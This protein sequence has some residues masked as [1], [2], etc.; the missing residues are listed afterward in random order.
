MRILWPMVAMVA[1]TGVAARQASPEL[2][3]T[4]DGVRATSVMGVAGRL[5]VDP[6]AP[7]MPV[8]NP[9]MAARAG[10]RSGPFAVQYG[11]GPVSIAGRTAVARIDLGRGAIKRRVTWTA[12]AFVDDA[13]AA[14]G[15][16]GLPDPV[17]RFQ[18]SAPRAGERVVTL[19]MASGGL[20]GGWGM[21]TALVPING[22]PVRIRFDPRRPTVATAG[23]GV[24]I[25]QAQGGT[26]EGA[27]ASTE[28]A[29]GV[30]RPVRGLR[31][32][33]PLAIGPL[34]LDR[35]LVR[36]SDFGSAASIAEAGAAPPDPDEVV[37]T[38]KGK[39]DRSRD[40]V[41][42]GREQLDRCSS[43]TF[44]KRAKLVRLSCV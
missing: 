2:V 17:I 20:F 37:V 25:A 39:R 42:L 31:L 24:A 27:P 7:A 26:L 6:A 35:L 19:P 11:V 30:V 36:V 38:A 1:A 21:T 23:A 33:R 29:F 15:P 16:G 13:D 8:L 3:I 14:V 28:I 9:A 43:I 34:A 22:Y 5:R 40:A 12:R 18:L 32:A 4:G 41:T 44:D 10:L